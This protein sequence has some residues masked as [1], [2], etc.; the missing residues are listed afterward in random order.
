MIVAWPSASNSVQS[1]ATVMPGGLPTTKGTQWCS[2]A[3]TLIPGLASMRSTC[4]IACLVTSPRASARP[5]PINATASEADSI[6]PSVAPASR[7]CAWHAGL[8]QTGFAESGGCSRTRSAFRLATRGP[9]PGSDGLEILSPVFLARIFS[10]HHYPKVSRP[11]RVF[12]EVQT[13]RWIFFLHP[14]P[15]RNE[16]SLEGAAMTVTAMPVAYARVL[17]KAAETIPTQRDKHLRNLK[18]PTLTTVAANQGC[19]S[20]FRACRR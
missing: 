3:S 12:R 17:S 2:R 20:E 6:A 4:L 9:L 13:V 10:A 19:R 14:S 8:R 7:G 5:C 1:M 16:G 11:V 18:M 15:N